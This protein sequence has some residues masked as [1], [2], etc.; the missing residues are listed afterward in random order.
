VHASEQDGTERLAGK[1]AVVT[2]AAR[3]IGRACAEGLRQEGAIVVALDRSWAGSDRLHPGADRPP[4]LSLE[5]DITDGAALAAAREHV[6]AQF[7]TVDVLV[8]NAALRQRD[9]YPPTGVASVL[10]TSDADW[11]R[12][13]QVNV[14]GTLKA[15]RVFIEPMLAQE[16]GSVV[17]VGSRGSLVRPIGDGVWS[18]GHPHIRNQP[19]DA[20]KAALTSLTF[21]LAAEVRDRNVAVNV[22]F[23]GP[24]MTTGS[25]D[26]LAGRRA[27]GIPT[28]EFLRADHVV[29]LALHLAMQRGHGGLT[30]TAMDALRWNET[31]GLGAPDAWVATA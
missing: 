23:P 25:A 13:L 11:E 3:G 12:M 19:Y 28:G 20:S 2:G 10:D 24:T 27:S 18:G 14:I 21:Y 26:I 8:N 22:L 30:G 16:S 5:V 17:N 29:P 1:V 6:V 9:L 4:A 15:T 31:H 7:G